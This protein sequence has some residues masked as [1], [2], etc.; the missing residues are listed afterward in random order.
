M[1][2]DLFEKIA[3]LFVGWL[4]GLLGPIIVESIKRKREDT[5]GRVAIL[6]ELKDLATTLA[7][8][9]Y[10]VH[11]RQGTFDRTFLEWLKADLEQH[12]IKLFP[13]KYLPNNFRKLNEVY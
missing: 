7:L 9:A 12:A 5:L 13:L 6:S 4:L 8:A 1:P 11:L 10:G 2:A 3:L